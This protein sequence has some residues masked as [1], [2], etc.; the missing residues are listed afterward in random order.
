MPALEDVAGD[1]HPDA[2]DQTNEGCFIHV[3]CASR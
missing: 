1:D 2:R 3:C